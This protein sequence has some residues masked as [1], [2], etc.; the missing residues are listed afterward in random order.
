MELLDAINE[1]YVTCPDCAK[2]FRVN[3]GNPRTTEQYEPTFMELQRVTIGELSTEWS[4]KVS[5]ARVHQRAIGVAKALEQISPLLP[6][7]PRDFR[8]ARFIGGLAPCDIMSLDGY[9]AGKTES[10]TFIEVKTGERARLTNTERDFKAVIDN[11]EMY[12]EILHI[13]L[14]ELIEYLEGA[15]VKHKKAERK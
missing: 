13:P 14:D 9:T 4:K 5:D 2:V 12:H 15:P 7:Y 11:G 1:I 10:L 6:G 8:D 3:E